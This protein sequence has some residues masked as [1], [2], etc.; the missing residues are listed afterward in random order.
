M[1][2][3]KGEKAVG[4]VVRIAL[5]LLRSSV[6]QVCAEGSFGGIQ[7]PQGDVGQNH[8]AGTYKR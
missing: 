7:V 6:S 4:V 3:G 1:V 5:R 8:Q 2:G